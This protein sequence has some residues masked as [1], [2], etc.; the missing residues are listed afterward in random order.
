MAN[1]TVQIG[2]YGTEQLRKLHKVLGRWDIV[3]LTVSGVIGVDTVA[4]AAQTG[5]QMITWTLL[6]AIFY[7]LPYGLITAE[8]SAAYP[9]EG[10]LYFW[11]R[12]AFGPYIGSVSSF[13]YWI[14]NPIWMGSLAVTG[15]GTLSAAYGWKL[16]AQDSMLLALVVVWLAT[17]IEVTYL[18]ISKWAVNVGAVIK[19]ALLL[20]LGGGALV[21][22]AVHG[23]AN[24]MTTAKFMPNF[25]TT[26][27]LMP[28]LIFNWVG[29]ELQSN[30]SEEIG[31]PRRDI[32]RSILISGITA[33]VGYSLGILGILVTTPSS[34]LSTVTGLLGAFQGIFSSP[35]LIGVVA[36]AIFI[37]YVVSGTTWLIGVDRSFA[38]SG[39]DGAIPR[40]FGHFHNKFG[41]PDRVAVL[42]GLVPTVFILVNYFTYH[43]SG[44]S[45]TYND[46][47]NAAFVAALFP[48]L[49]MLPA[50]IVLRRKHPT[51][52]SPYR[53]PGGT[54]GLWLAVIFS[55]A[56]SFVA[57]LANFIPSALTGVTPAG[58]RQ[59]LYYLLGEL[60]VASLFFLWARAQRTEYETVSLDAEPAAD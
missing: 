50:V 31:N 35:I 34:K 45:S 30:A 60:V 39:W 8:L 1:N 19:F 37:G 58:A 18:R 46:L 12:Q 53:V 52:K 11:V 23:A 47:L 43:A 14:S 40:F 15:I 2:T 32:P 22:V 27:V 21:A 13:L 6:S 5:Y 55:F 57:V 36:A 25:G 28:V 17:G 44:L 54:I 42:S 4:Y 48:Y 26:L 49:F 51:L 24:P 10:G 59:M 3:L 41:T 7:L 33:A 38:T 56:F 16:S 20:L 9:K 29:F